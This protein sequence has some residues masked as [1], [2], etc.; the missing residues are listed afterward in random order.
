MSYDKKFLDKGLRLE[1]EGK[2][3]DAAE[4]YV[5]TCLKTLNSEFK[6]TASEALGRYVALAKQIILNTAFRGKDT[7]LI[8][9]IGKIQ[10]YF[11][12]NF[13]R[14]NN[15][16]LFDESELLQVYAIDLLIGKYRLGNLS[17]L[18]D[19]SLKQPD[20]K[21]KLLDALVGVEKISIID[22]ASNLGFSSIATL[23]LVEAGI[24]QN[25]FN[26]HLTKDELNK[27]YFS[28][29]YVRVFLAKKLGED[30]SKIIKQTTTVYTYPIPPGPSSVTLTKR[31]QKKLIASIFIIV[32]VVA[33]VI[34]GSYFAANPSSLPYPTLTA[35]P[36]PTAKEN[37]IMQGISIDS[38]HKILTMYA[39]ST[40][41]LTPVVNNIIIKDASGSTIAIVSIASISP[42]APGNAL[43]TGT[44]YTITSAVLTNAL[45]SGTYTAT[46]TTVA[47]GSFIS[48]AYLLSN[49]G[50]G[51]TTN[52]TPTPTP[53]PNGVATATTLSFSANVT[54]GG[55]T[56]EYKWS[57]KDIHAN[58]I[59]RVDFA[60]YSYL[61]DAGQQKAWS[62]TDNGATWTA[63]TNFVA[64]W[65]A[66]GAQWT[67]Y[68]DN[69]TH[70]N[71]SNA[72]YQ[73]SN[74]AGEAIVIYN[75]TVNPTIPASTFTV[76]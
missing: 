11:V 7:D 24:K 43:A 60:G 3:I 52:P 13:S 40:G 27:I 47:G 37:I 61:L 54:S 26:G 17:F 45:G 34:G 49:N 74:P 65:T 64:D 31:S 6:P 12:E 19:E 53:I 71:G 57:G 72:N 50:N 73:Y 59:I 33:A 10:S 35:S 18:A 14:K 76:S 38:T 23:K 63:S 66:W 55:Q 48:P 25:A 46:L 15:D 28:S 39:Q 70:W 16:K 21:Q 56:T 51:G 9:R 30:S 58:M 42:T 1:K 5:K 75:I 4:C 41:G 29:D 36:T 68:V 62:S 8:D 69:L 20:L 44:L 67:T 32:I 22:L 2:L